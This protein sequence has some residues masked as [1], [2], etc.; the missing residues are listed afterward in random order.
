MDRGPQDDVRQ[1]ESRRAQEDKS[2]VIEIAQIDVDDLESQA[3][4]QI[5]KIVEGGFLNFNDLKNCDTQSVSTCFTN[6]DQ[7]QSV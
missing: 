3:T 1:A 6:D 2:K 4:K 5:N 7:Y